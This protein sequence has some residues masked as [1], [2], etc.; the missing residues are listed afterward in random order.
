MWVKNQRNS[1]HGLDFFYASD[2]KMTDYLKEYYGALSAV[3]DS[4]G[5]I[6]AFLEQSGLDD[7]TMV[8]FYSDNGF[9]IGD[10]GLIDKRNAYE[11]S[12]RVPMV[13]SAPGRLPA[14]AVNP[15][16]VRNLDLAPTFLDAA[17]VAPPGHFEGKSAL[18]VMTGEIDTAAW[19]EPDFIYEYYWEWSFPMTPTTYA[20]Q[21][22]PLKY[23]QYHGVWDIEE[24]YDV[25]ADPLEKHNLIDDPDY[26]SVRQTLRLALYRQLADDS[27]RHAVPFHARLAQGM[28]LR[29]HDGPSAAPFPDRWKVEPNRIDKHNGLFPDTPQKKQFLDAGMPYI[30]WAKPPPQRKSPEKQ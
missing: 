27:G 8:V 2:R 5:R 29:R 21:R 13:V 28:N 20:I 14:G 1:W 24:L 19:G 18:P 30:P 10:H 11:G 7:H 12:V 15:A 17:G 6:T 22:G 16:R 23:I 25:E 4:V 3:D 26:Y 9:L